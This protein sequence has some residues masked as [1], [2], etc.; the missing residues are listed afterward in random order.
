MI[1]KSDRRK[2]LTHTTA[3]AVGAAAG[4]LLE[5]PATAQ[6]PSRPAAPDSSAEARL[7][8]L[9][10]ELPKPSAP[11]AT[12]VPAVQ[13]GNLLFVSGHGPRNADGTRITGKVGPRAGQMSTG[14]ANRAA[15]SVGL[16]VLST[17]REA[18]GSLD[19][20]ARTVKVLGMVNASPEFTEHPQVINGFSDLLVQVFGERGKGARSAVGMSSLPGDIPVEIEVIFEVRS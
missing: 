11:V 5:R 4:T 6:E 3:A 12:Y 20:V 18:L 14:D 15:R 13:V 19:R 8:E 7:R 16:A 2:F 10:I 1:T 9:K 17:V